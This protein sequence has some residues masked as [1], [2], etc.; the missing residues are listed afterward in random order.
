M[1]RECAANE[2]AVSAAE[3]YDERSGSRSVSS[4]HDERHQSSHCDMIMIIK[5]NN[6]CGRARADGRPEENLVGL[7]DPSSVVVWGGRLSDVAS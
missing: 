2:N 3:T 1:S 7:R 6:G 4:K 5:A